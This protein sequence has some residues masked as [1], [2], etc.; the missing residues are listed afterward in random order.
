MAAVL[1]FCLKKNRKMKSYN[2]TSKKPGREKKAAFQF[3]NGIC[4]YASNEEN[5]RMGV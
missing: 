1:L 4:C 2:G 5:F 3:K